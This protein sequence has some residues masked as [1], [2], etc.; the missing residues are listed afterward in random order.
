V[1][2]YA[3]AVAK[4]PRFLK[5]KTRWRFVV[6][7][8]SMDDHAKEKAQQKDRAK[9]LVYDSG[10]LHIQVWAYE[11]TE[12]IANARSRL[13]FINSSLSYEAGR[14]TSRAYLEKVHSQFIPE[15][16]VV[17]REPSAPG[18]QVP[19]SEPT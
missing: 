19:E 18:D 16:D 6:V 17:S 13:Q 10:T 15:V 1:E 7:S 14:E 5:E 2:S 8:N 12:I 3:I 9:G 4:D 11:W